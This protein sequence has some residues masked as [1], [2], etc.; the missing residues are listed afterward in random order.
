M[1]YDVR[2]PAPPPLTLES[3]AAVRL[4]VDGWDV[5]GLEKSI[6]LSIAFVADVDLVWAF[7]DSEQPDTDYIVMPPE[8]VTKFTD[9]IEIS[10]PGLSVVSLII[11]RVQ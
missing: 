10:K 4:T 11:Q 9:H 5:T 2:P 1:R 6:G 3:I 8:G 7:F